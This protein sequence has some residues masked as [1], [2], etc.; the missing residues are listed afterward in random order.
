MIFVNAI[1]TYF[2][3]NDGYQWYAL[4]PIGCSLIS[5]VFVNAGVIISGGDMKEM[6]KNRDP[7][8]SVVAFIIDLIVAFAL[9]IMLVAN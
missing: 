8:L 4:I 2:V 6:I 7:K 9:I 5:T 3:W 1:L